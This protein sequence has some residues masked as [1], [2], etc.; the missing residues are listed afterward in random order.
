M[1][2]SAAMPG[3][4]AWPWLA[5]LAVAL[6]IVLAYAGTFSSPFAFDD[7]DSIV[8]NP[9]LRPG[10]T[11][12][13]VLS[14]PYD[15]GQTVGGRPVL[16]M[17]L[18]LN[19]RWG[20]LSVTGYHVVNLA[21]HVGAALLLMGLVRRTCLLLGGVWEERAR[22]LGFAVACLWGLHPLQTEAV[23]YV[24]Q[25]AES[26]MGAW[27]L[28]T[29]YAYLR[30]ATSAGGRAGAWFGLSVIGCW[31]GM[32][33]KEVMVSAPLIVL[34]YDR[35]FIAGSLREA[36]RRRGG[37]LALLASSWLLLAVLVAS[38]HGRGGTLGW[39]L[40]VTW[41]GYLVT[42][43]WALVHYLFLVVWPGSLIFDY[44]AEGVPLADAFAQV[45]L[46][47]LGV[48]A[49]LVGAWRR[50][51]WGFLAVW[52]LAILA[53]T[54][55]IPGNRQV[56]AEHRVYLALAPLLALGLGG[57][58]ALIRRR[59]A[60]FER[61][62]IAVTAVLGALLLTA[63]LTRNR[64]YG[65]GLILWS[66]TVAK[67]PRNAYAHNNLGNEWRLQGDLDRATD[68]FRQAI[69]LK[70]DLA[71]AHNNLGNVARARGLFRAAQLEY[72]EAIR[73]RP[74]YADAYS[75]LGGALV[76]QGLFTEAM[77]PLSQA[78]RLR[79]DYPEALYNM[80]LTCEGAQ[81]MPEA[82]GY[83][84]RALIQDPLLAE[85]RMNLALL[86]VRKGSLAEALGEF[87][88]L[89]ADKPSY[90][91]AHYNYGNALALA[92]RFAEAEGQYGEAARLDPSDT[93]AQANLQRLR[94]Y[95]AQVGGTSR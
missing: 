79:P 57:V 49:A 72:E 4:S 80:G 18:A 36:L 47:T 85:A 29:V 2:A 92:S 77:E 83:Y 81:R 17:S 89:V 56:I 45:V 50:T 55:L 44:G 63:T 10:S 95:E 12:S 24:V 41:G 74:G 25:R 16:N 6:L 54:S 65:S 87:S 88:R 66:D 9:T 7:F 70:P 1:G 43:A 39:D 90:A 31:L 8:K 26:L 13:E 78:L 23:T 61:G 91:L 14:P 11:L 58:A 64:V 21:I 51:T 5:P 84:R 67:R 19:Y 46:C 15:Q 93:R 60:S 22:V 3:R 37:V 27:Y 20:G 48:A 52:F 75:N 32:A 71:E 68:E 34:L 86:L 82:E 53:P 40:G 73:F 28:L 59:G 94:A 76:A 42:Q 35:T 38:V 62:T 33:T 69:A 30:G